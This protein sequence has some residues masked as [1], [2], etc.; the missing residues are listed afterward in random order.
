MV[1]SLEDALK[2]SSIQG[3]EQADVG[4]LTEEIIAQQSRSRSPAAAGEPAV[5]GEWAPFRYGLEAKSKP[6][7]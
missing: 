4:G 2:R 3:R 7:R 5:V 1:V 6:R